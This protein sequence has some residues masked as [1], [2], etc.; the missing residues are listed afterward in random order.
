MQQYNKRKEVLLIHHRFEEY[1][2]AFYPHPAQDIDPIGMWNIVTQKRLDGFVRLFNNPKLPRS[3][4][5]N[6]DGTFRL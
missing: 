5:S 3:S 6:S 4:K 2:D 1:L